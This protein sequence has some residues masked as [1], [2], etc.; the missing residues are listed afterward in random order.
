[1]SAMA[2][3]ILDRTYARSVT[4][5]RGDLSSRELDVLRTAVQSA[6]RRSR[7]SHS[8]R[9]TEHVEVAHEEHLPQAGCDLEG[10]RGAHT[11]AARG[12]L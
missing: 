8:L 3:E 6:D 1:M 11:G 9:V 4:A 10:G 7:S 2:A 12:L 5:A